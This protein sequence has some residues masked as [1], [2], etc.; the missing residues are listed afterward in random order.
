MLVVVCLAVLSASRLRPTTSLEDLF[1]RDRSAVDAL[2]H[3]LEDFA[4]AEELIL[5]AQGADDA[6][7]SQVS[8]ELLAF[9]Q[10]LEHAFAQDPERPYGWRR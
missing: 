7:A 10:R 2:H 9:A 1:P 3:L 6:L 8:A 5:L 4:A